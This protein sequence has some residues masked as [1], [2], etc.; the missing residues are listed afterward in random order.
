MNSRKIPIAN[1]YY[2]LCYAWR[3]VEESDVVQVSELEGLERVQDLLGKVL[4][5]GTFLLIRRG[6]DRDYR[7]VHENLA[8][9]RGKIDMGK[10]VKQALRAQGKVACTFEEMSHDVVHNRILRSTLKSLM[11]LPEL[12]KE[13]RADVRSAYL[14]LAGVT[15]VPL[16]R[17]LFQRVHL[18]RNRGHYRF[19]LSVCQLIHE[20]LLVDENSGETRF[21]E[22]SEKKMWELY[23]DFIIEFYR[24]EQNHYHVNHPGRGIPWA[25]EGTSEHHR[26]KL[27]QMEADVIFESLTRRIIM[28][29]K[30]YPEAFNRRYEGKEKLRSDH[31]YQLLA[32]LRNREATETP[33]AKH[34]G[35]LLYPTVDQ[36]VLVDVCLE[37]FSIHARSINLAQDWHK[38]HHDMLALIE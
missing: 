2:L 15:V 36:H 10:T 32:Y 19:L 23:E 6:L 26:S 33:G 35:I 38:I 11:Q 17:R 34:E 24:C 12:H 14:K 13:V 1:I 25:S 7:D 22:I 5:Q 28:D 29:A 3:H 20:Q 8:G 4:S 27:P 37:G 18:D 16:S 31:L 21:L 30:Y 9:I